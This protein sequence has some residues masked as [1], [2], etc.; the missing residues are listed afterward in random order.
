MKTGLSRYFFPLC[1]LILLLLVLT[2]PTYRTWALVLTG[3]SLVMVLDKIGKGIVLR[4][5]IAFHSCFICLL[6]PVLGYEIYNIDNELAR[7]WVRNMPVASDTYFSYVLPAL[8][9]LIIPMTWPLNP[10]KACDYGAF[11]KDKV[12]IIKSKLVQRP[13]LGVYLIVIGVGM[14][15]VSNQVPEALRFVAILV[16]WTSF[17]GFLYLYFL[18]GAKFRLP[19]L[20]IFT[21]FIFWDALKTGMFTI[22]VYMGITMFSYFFIGRSV[23]FW[24]KL[25]VFLL[26]GVALIVIQ[27]VK[28]SY[29]SHTWKGDY[30][31][32]EVGL[33]A[34]LVKDRVTSGSGFFNPN[35][36]FFIYYRTNQGYNVALVMRR[37]P[38][39]KPYD[40]GAAL[41]QTLAGALVPRAFWPNKPEAGGKFNMKYFAGLTLRGWS[42]NVSPLGEAYGSFGPVGGAIYLFFLG[43]FIRLAYRGLF[44]FSRK[45]PILVLWIPVLFYQTSYSM[46]TD[47]LQILN[48]L[49]KAAVF[50]WAL[51][52]LFPSIFFV[53][54]KKY[55]PRHIATAP[56][57]Q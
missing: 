22:V 10:K 34:N 55:L 39:I 38:A 54:R 33:F 12:E 8:C 47:T 50:V 49:F 42:T 56:K 3:L 32:N 40:G 6:M 48:S 44:H 19:I 45:V 30:A 18:R 29:R 20:I 5:L 21:A 36:F 37:M 26:C 13:K 14:Y 46:E 17:T 57:L 1:Q 15:L 7:L 24:K 16:Y 52:K 31:G 2:V 35:A 43:I 9:M 11:L 53:E 23:A 41:T 25:S 4:E 27:S 51:Y 28:I